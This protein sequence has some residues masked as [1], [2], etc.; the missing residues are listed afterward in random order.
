MTS[1]ERNERSLARSFGELA[2][3]YIELASPWNRTGERFIDA[4]YEHARQAARHARQSIDAHDRRTRPRRRG[5]ECKAG[6]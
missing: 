1:F 4:A 2:R 3:G 5:D 6:R